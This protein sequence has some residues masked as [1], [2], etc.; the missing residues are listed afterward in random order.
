[1]V[2]P[3]AEMCWPGLYINHAFLGSR[4]YLVSYPCIG[5]Y[6]YVCVCISMYMYVYVCVCIS[7]Y[8]Y[9]YLCI[10]M[11]MYVCLRCRRSGRAGWAIHMHPHKNSNTTPSLHQPPHT[12]RLP[13]APPID[14]HWT[15]SFQN[16][17]F[18]HSSPWSEQQQTHPKVFPGGPPPQP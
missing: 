1:M 14:R 8:M 3:S 10:C 6:K 4:I 13:L 16:K 9:V 17:S 2:W 18:Q 5:M 11:Y 7:M 15:H 12:A